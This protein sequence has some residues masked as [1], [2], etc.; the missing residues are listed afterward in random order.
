MATVHA[1]SP[2]L[3]QGDLLTG[4]AHF[5]ETPLDKPMEMVIFLKGLVDLRLNG[6]LQTYRDNHG[7]FRIKAVFD[8]LPELP[9]TYF[10]LSMTRKLLRN[11]ATCGRH[12][13]IGLLSGHNDDDRETSSQTTIDM[14]DRQR[15]VPAFNPSLE[16]TSSDNQAAAHPETVRAV[17]D[18]P[19]GQQVLSSMRLVLPKGMMGNPNAAP[20]CSQIQANIDMC[21]A[22]S[23]IGKVRASARIFEFLGEDLDVDGKLYM[24]EPFLDG[25]PGGAF[26]ILDLPE[27]AGGGYMILNVRLVLNDDN[28]IEAIVTGLPTEFDIRRIDMS[29]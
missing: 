15:D 10:E 11:P 22:N 6:K 26:L 28:R 20:K 29:L 19:A 14:C 13:F 7:N 3:E 12:T 17:V 18:K 27:V 5:K 23:K 16:F 25:D 24:A 9:V 8:D 21:P 4:T 1:G 2:L